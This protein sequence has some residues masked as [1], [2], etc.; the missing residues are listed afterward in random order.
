MR[1]SLKSVKKLRELGAKKL[2]F[3]DNYLAQ[4]EFFDRIEPEQSVNADLPVTAE[5]AQVLQ[6][7]ERE[8]L[9]YG[10]S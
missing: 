7:L 3:V 6:D 1:N 10:S 8:R 2:I 9:R 4:I 5:E